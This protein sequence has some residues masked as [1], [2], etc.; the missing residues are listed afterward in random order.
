MAQ[1]GGMPLSP[2]PGNGT[3]PNNMQ[4]PGMP[5]Q[6]GAPTMG[7]GAMQFGPATPGGGGYQMQNNTYGGAPSPSS[8][9]QQWMQMARGGASPQQFM[10]TFG[11][12]LG[13]PAMG[14]YQG[15]QNDPTD[16]MYGQP[17]QAM[18]NFA[19]ILSGGGNAS[20]MSFSPAGPDYLSRTLNRGLG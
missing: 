17:Q 11:G 7:H 5:T 1:G 3:V 10:Q 13:A 9:A 2:I 15:R 8:L 12:G 4:R 20:N 18:P 14:G 19:Q 6:P 16:P